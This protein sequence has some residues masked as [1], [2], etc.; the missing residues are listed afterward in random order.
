ML[1]FSSFADKIFYFNMTTKKKPIGLE[2]KKI[3]S[4]RLQNFICFCLLLLALFI[5]F[6]EIFFK[7]GFLWE[8]F[9]EQNYPDRL[10][11]T[12]A[13]RD[14][15]FP[16]WNPYI[17]GGLPFY[18]A[19]QPG[20]LFLPN[21]FL[22][23]FV[24]GRWLSSY[25]VEI[26]I[27]LH[28][29]IAGSG[30]FFFARENKFSYGSAFFMA[31]SYM[32][33]GHFI[34]HLTH[35][36]QVQTLVFI[37]WIFLFLKRATVIENKKEAWSASLA[38]GLLLGLAG[39]AGYPQAMVII[40]TGVGLYFLYQLITHFSN[41]LGL[42]LRF[43]VIIIIMILII[44]CQYIPTYCLFKESI[45]ALYT[46][47]EIVEGSFHPLRFITFLI[48]NFFG[49][50]AQGIIKNYWGPGPYYQ[51]WEQMAYVGIIPLILSAYAF[52]KNWRKEVILPLI[53]II[54]PLLI[55]L[56]KYFPLHILLYK[57]VPFFK[58]IRTPAKFLNIT[59]FGLI[60]LSGLGLESLLEYK[61]KTK[62]LAIIGWSL[63]LI[64]LT[65]I[66]FIPRIPIRT[67]A[68]K[69][70]IRSIII[71]LTATLFTRSYLRNR[72]TRKFFIVL[73]AL[74]A[75][76]D[77]FTFGYRYN[78]SPIDPDFY[79]R[80]DRLTNFFRKEFQTE[81]VRVN[82]RCPE[83]MILPRNIGYVQEFPTVDGYN[84][85]MLRRFHRARTV[86]SQERFLALMGV[87]Y[88]TYYDST[89]NR[90]NI[91]Q[92]DYYLP[93]AK[94]FYDWEVITDPE[95]ILLCLNTSNFPLD[96]KVMLEQ[97]PN[98]L[99]AK[100]EQPSGQIRIISYHPNRIK[101]TVETEKPAILVLSENYYPAWRVKING[102]K[103]KIFPVDYF[104]SGCVVPQGAS[105][106]E[107]YYEEKYF[108]PLLIVAIFTILVTL[109]LIF[110]LSKHRTFNKANR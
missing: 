9:L 3:C 6:F 19:I 81:Y 61:P 91:K 74:L 47:E 24:T 7:K 104:L 82:I 87:K 110:I 43:M 4:G 5:F 62:F 83:G 64:V 67:I 40:L 44:A 34:V 70:S 71:I 45:R 84:P 20:T 95:S 41:A 68:I 77:L 76:G 26:F 35:T 58:D 12:R 54:V 93:R 98:I 85:L 100:E 88:F 97:V 15:I 92:A 17:F 102:K 11:A 55:G 42:L 107:F 52:Y 90:V 39:L 37:P 28:L 105:M 46:Y 65:L 56:G 25:L 23:L 14:G 72:L 27:I 59:I 33:N 22:T 108:I 2:R 51:Y 86:L 31:L 79:W 66:F 8:D 94:L 60:W 30:M 106:V 29:L 63:T 96:R 16:F 36:Q 53:I 50:T 32:L 1:D 103:Y 89:I 48:P 101:L 18:A 73:I 78:S 75:F 57:F 10:F 80:E 38:C 13:L 109:S 49:T 69:D 99:P 21:L